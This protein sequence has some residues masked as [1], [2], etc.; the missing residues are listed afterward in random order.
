M[1]CIVG[2]FLMCY[3]VHL[4]KTVYKFDFAEMVPPTTAG[5]IVGRGKEVV[6]GAVRPLLGN[7]VGNLA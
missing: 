6:G 7:G 1:V 2:G 4:K 5:Y 3:T